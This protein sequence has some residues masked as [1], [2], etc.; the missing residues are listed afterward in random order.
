[1][2]VAVVTFAHV[3]KLAGARTQAGLFE[4]FAFGGFAQQLT[5]LLSAARKIP[6]R[7]RMIRIP[8]RHQQHVA[9]IARAANDQSGC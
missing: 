8:R 3:S 7:L 4:Q 5:R 1:M 9:S 2:R 6:Q